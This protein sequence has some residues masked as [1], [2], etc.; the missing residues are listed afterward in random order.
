MQDKTMAKNSTSGRKKNTTL[1]TSTQKDVSYLQPFATHRHIY[2][3]YAQCGEIVNFHH[4]I[5]K[6][7]LD[8]YVKY[9]DPHYRYNQRCPACV[10]EFLNR[11]YHWYLSQINS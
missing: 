9:G 3:L 4:H 6:E 1:P 5:Q 7:L 2:D 11:V 8:T 10:A